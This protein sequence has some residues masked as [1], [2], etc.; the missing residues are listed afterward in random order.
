PFDGGLQ[1]GAEPLRGPVRCAD[2][3][4][5]LTAE[6]AEERRPADAAVLLGGIAVEAREERRPA[7]DD[8]IP[9]EID[10][11]VSALVDR[12]RIVEIA[13]ELL[14]AR[15]G[16]RSLG[17]EPVQRELPVARL[18]PEVARGDALEIA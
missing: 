18:E 12:L 8:P 7:R 3:P 2:A 10:R 16:L 15:V 13:Q 5:G 6:A 11:A 1:L 9:A 14:N 4:I 17:E